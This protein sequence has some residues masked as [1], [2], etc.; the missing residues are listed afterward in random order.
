MKILFL[1]NNCN[2]YVLAD[3]LEEIGE[4]VIR[5]EERVDMEYLKEIKP[6]LIVSYNYLSIIRQEIITYMKGNIINLHISYL[7]FNK[8]KFPNVWSILDHT[9][10]GVT[11]HY[12]DE[13]L[14]TGDIIA[15]KQLDIPNSVTLQDSY[16]QLQEEIQALFK[17]IYPLKAQWRQMS[18]PQGGVGTKHTQK[19]FDE[20]VA[21]IIH[22][23]DMT[24]EQ[25]L[26]LYEERYGTDTGDC[27][28]S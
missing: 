24:G 14:D 8:G 16:D 4:N 9:P 15:Q 5:S 20:K 25:L 12:I 22:S 7:P 1:T 13:K 10:K 28:P 6:D 17:E 23:W 27:S 3:W 26:E 2:A 18:Y 11:I 19:D 21:A